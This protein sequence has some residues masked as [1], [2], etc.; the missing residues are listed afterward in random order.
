MVDLQIGASVS[1][2]GVCLSVT[3]MSGNPVTFDA[4]AEYV[5]SDRHTLKLNVSNLTDELY[6]DSL[7]RGFYVPGAARSVQLT[8]KTRF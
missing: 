7:Y 1:V 3:S 4:M 6:A 8:L 5:M 2:E